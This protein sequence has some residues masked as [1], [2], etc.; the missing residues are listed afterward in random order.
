M[1]RSSR[2]DRVSMP[3][4]AVLVGGG[5]WRGTGLRARREHDC[6]GRR[7]ERRVVFRPWPRRTIRRPDTVSSIRPLVVRAEWRKREALLFSVAH[8]DGL[9]VA[10]K[11]VD[12]TW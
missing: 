1:S 10:P 9:L 6:D 7:D 12:A 2:L 11:R 8:G 3:A 5:R 4:D